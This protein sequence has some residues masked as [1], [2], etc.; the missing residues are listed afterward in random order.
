MS[1]LRTPTTARSVLRSNPRRRLR[2]DARVH[3]DSFTIEKPKR[4]ANQSWGG[5][6]PIYEQP[7]AYWMRATFYDPEVDRDPR[8]FEQDDFWD[9]G[10]DK[11]YK[12]MGMGGVWAWWPSQAGW[13]AGQPGTVEYIAAGNGF[14]PDILE[15]A[16]DLF[17]RSLELGKGWSPTIALFKRYGGAVAPKGD[18]RFLPVHRPDARLYSGMF[19]VK[20]AASDA[21]NSRDY[22]E[23]ILPRYQT[24]GN[25]SVEDPAKLAADEQR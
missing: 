12:R 16:A 7:G 18:F 14:G 8:E 5:P 23:G 11:F 1:T 17:E 25:R 3:V 20:T 2:A 19:A 21:Y 6:R 22:S 24:D 10:T 9:E 15:A 4:Q 13:A